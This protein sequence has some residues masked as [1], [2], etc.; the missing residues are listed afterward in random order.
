MQVDQ[1]KSLA[2]HILDEL[3]PH[4]FNVLLAGGAV[5]DWYYDKEANDL[6]FFISGEPRPDAL[7]QILGVEI[8]CLTEKT[9]E[10]SLFEGFECEIDGQ[11]CQ[12]L[13]HQCDCPK[14]L[15]EDKFP[16]SSSKGWYDGEEFWYSREFLIGDR[17]GALIFD[18][19]KVSN[20][21]YVNKLIFRLKRGEAHYLSMREFLRYH[22]RDN[23][24]NIV[25]L[26]DD[27]FGGGGIGQIEF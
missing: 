19:S 16:V 3:Q 24:V 7:N 15:V 12:F 13:F 14:T 18:E 1:Q 27:L 25:Q 6:D 22:F 2:K 5:R 26:D 4:G 21:D 20:W 23:P 10:D 9:Y 8:R 11:V 17:Y